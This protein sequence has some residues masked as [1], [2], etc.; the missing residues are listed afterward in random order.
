M[1]TKISI[2]QSQIEIEQSKIRNDMSQISSIASIPKE[3]K[4]SWHFFKINALSKEIDGYTKNIDEFNEKLMPLKAELNRM[5]TEVGPLKFLATWIY[6]ETDSATDKAVQLFII[7][8]VTVFDPLAL[9]LI[10]AGIHGFELE[11]HRKATGVSILP[12]TT[13]PPTTLYTSETKIEDHP[14]QLLN[15]V[16]EPSEPVVQQQQED[17]EEEEPEI[18]LLPSEEEEEEEVKKA[19]PI[20]SEE[21]WAIKE[22]LASSFSAAPEPIETP[23]PEPTPVVPEPEVF[24][25]QNLSKRS[26]SK[27]LKLLNKQPTDAIDAEDTK[28]LLSLLGETATSLNE[29]HVKRLQKLLEV[30]KPKKKSSPKNNVVPFP[31]EDEREVTTYTNNSEFDEQLK[32]INYLK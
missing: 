30:P 8:L 22:M 29:E 9:L 2:L 24:L 3:E 7:M 26:V 17:E 32:N 23:E 6:G 11:K 31:S 13:T 18:V 1:Q 16:P 19:K 20:V 25:Q 5:N 12:F 28:R 27:L 15:T 14:D 21:D 10:F 4:Q